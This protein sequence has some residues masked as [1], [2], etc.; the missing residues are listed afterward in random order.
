MPMRLN[1]SIYSSKQTVQI[2]LIPS[3]HSTA[4]AAE[5]VK[6]ACQHVADANSAFNQTA[7]QMID[8]LY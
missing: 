1:L 7:F 4:T 3:A 2:E 8:G 5:D 6:R